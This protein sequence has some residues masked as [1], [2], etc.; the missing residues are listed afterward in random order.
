MRNGLKLLLNFLDNFWGFVFRLHQFSFDNILCMCITYLL[1][2]KLHHFVDQFSER[3]CGGIYRLLSNIVLEYSSGIV[4]SENVS[5]S[6]RITESGTTK[7]TG[8][9]FLRAP[10]THY[11]ASLRKNRF[12]A[13]DAISLLCRLVHGVIEVSHLGPAQ[14]LFLPMF[15]MGIRH[16]VLIT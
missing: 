11:P 8:H 12:L 6:F 1:L 13:V 15:C 5:G 16:D 7:R 10:N 9:I 3:V 14:G 4:C 2:L